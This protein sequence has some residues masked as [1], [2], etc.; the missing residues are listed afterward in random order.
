MSD[1]FT[2]TRAV[3]PQ[4]AFDSGRLAAWLRAHVEGFSGELTVE[5]FKGGQSNPTFLLTAGS[6]AT[7]M[8][9]KPP[10]KL[11]PSAHAVDREFRVISALAG[12]DVPVAR[13]LLLCEDESV[14]GTRLL[15]DGLRRRPRA[16]GPGAARHDERRARRHL[17]R[18][19]PRDRRAAP[20]RRTQAVG[21][22]DYG[23]PGNY[24][25]RQIGRWSKQYRASE[26][27][28]IEAMDAPDRLAAGAHAGA[29]TRRPSCTATTGSTT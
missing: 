24:F 3:S 9:R 25:A 26:T 5:Q 13:M 4:H 15:R 27:E 12:T 17:R 7:C 29:A 22:A 14:I 23:K 21:L 28:T 19:E 6:S 18:D 20:R 10:G 16:V 8:R 11:L 1:K 2:G